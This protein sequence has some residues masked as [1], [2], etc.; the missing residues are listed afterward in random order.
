M[1]FDIAPL[2][3]ALVFTDASSSPKT[4]LPRYMDTFAHLIDWHIGG[5][6]FDPKTKAFNASPRVS[7]VQVG[8]DSYKDLVQRHYGVKAGQGHN[9][10]PFNSDHQQLS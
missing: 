8:E 1:G 7:T 3:E 9:P 4:A 2:L 10:P 5:S 6:I